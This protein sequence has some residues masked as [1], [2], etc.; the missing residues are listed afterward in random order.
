MTAENANQR[1]FTRVQVAARTVIRSGDTVI[2]GAPTYSLSMKGMS[3]QTEQ[4]LPLG[5]PCQF[6]IVLVEGE[7]EIQAEGTVVAHRPDGLAF[8]FNK[9]VGLE[10]F[11]HLRNLVC[12][13]APD[14]DQ[15]ESELASHTGI[16]R[17]E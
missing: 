8:L 11:E 2:A 12:Y 1:E 3:V 16:R 13:N 4:R 5:A 14:L 10:S 7:V 15:V 9:I 6:T 17:R